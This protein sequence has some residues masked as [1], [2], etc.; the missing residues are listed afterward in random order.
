MSAGSITGA[1][2]LLGKSQPVVTRL[3]QV[4]E[5]DVGFALLHRSGPR[6]APTDKGVL[7]HGEIERLLIGLRHIRERADAISTSGNA[8]IEVVATQTLA[9]GLVPMAL[10]GLAPH[11]M[12]SRVHLRSSSAEEV[13]QSILARTADIGVASLPIDHPGLEIHWIGEAPC[14][15]VVSATSDLAR[16][17]ILPLAALTG[18]RIITMANPY[19]LRRRIDLA[20]AAANVVPSDLIETN[21]S[22]NAVMSAR[23]G[24]GV[25]LVD[26]ATALGIP[27]Q[28]VVVRAIDAHIPFVFGTVTSAGRP[29]SHAVQSL[30]DQIK[31]SAARL[32]PGFV[33]R[34]SGEMDSLSDA[35]YGP[36]APPQS[37]RLVSEGTR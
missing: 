36:N 28:G 24:L 27:V 15:A 31:V 7:F 37:G 5:T 22:L 20:L 33:S 21:A 19:R 2:R 6:I 9:S 11:D 14:V 25:A 30:I 34:T 29:V 23:A 17:G 10:A 16:D 32:L 18:H 35:I 1:A 3:I 8:P 4:L 26:P 13:V 12:P